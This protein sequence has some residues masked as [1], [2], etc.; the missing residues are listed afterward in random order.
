MSQLQPTDRLISQNEVARLLGTT[1]EW[2]HKRRREGAFP[3]PFVLGNRVKFVEREVHLWLEEHR[4]STGG[5]CS[6]EVV[7]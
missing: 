7:R 1:K 3:E 6:A 4:D 5:Q 2:V